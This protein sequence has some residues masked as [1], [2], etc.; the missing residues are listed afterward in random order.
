M[1]RCSEIVS[2]SYCLKPEEMLQFEGELPPNHS[3]GARRQR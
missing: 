1:E 3:T 2:D